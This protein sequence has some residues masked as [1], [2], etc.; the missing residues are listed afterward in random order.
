MTTLGIGITAYG[1]L[2]RG[3]TVLLE[4]GCC[5]QKALARNA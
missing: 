2:S 3:P 5:V 4:Q 1:V